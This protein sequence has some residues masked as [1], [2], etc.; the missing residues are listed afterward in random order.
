MKHFLN[1]YKG[2]VKKEKQIAS[3]PCWTQLFYQYDRKKF[4]TF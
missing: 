4:I 1:I 3:R 2:A